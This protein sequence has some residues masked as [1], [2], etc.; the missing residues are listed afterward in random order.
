MTPDASTPI[1]HLS[2]FGAEPPGLPDGL[3]T[4][5]QRS[6]DHPNATERGVDPRQTNHNP[7]KGPVEGGGEQDVV[8]EVDVDVGVGLQMGEAPVGPDSWRIR[9]WAP[10]SRSR[11]LVIG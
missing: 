2:L 5:I 6:C 7:S 1:S 4:V 10:G 8:L 9:R 11:R 3:V